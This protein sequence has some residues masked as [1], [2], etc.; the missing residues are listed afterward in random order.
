MST[1]RRPP[2]GRGRR[3]ASEGSA[4]R[5]RPA[6]SESPREPRR[7][8]D[9]LARVLV[10]IPAAILAI[11]FVDLGGTAWAVLMIAIAI[12]CL[13]ELYTLLARWRPASVVG[14]A[15][16]AALVLAARFGSLRDVLE[17]TMATLPIVFF[18][19]AARGRSGLSTVSV[20]GTLFGVY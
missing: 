15:S 14:F 11:V 17:I 8:S 19:V 4:R 6:R 1:A 20:A 5:S 12:A 2:S 7:R 10:A 9:L 18:V 3:Q 13:F 16:A